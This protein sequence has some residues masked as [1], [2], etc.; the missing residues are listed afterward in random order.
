[1]ELSC[2]SEPQQPQ[3]LLTSLSFPINCILMMTKPFVVAVWIHW[4]WNTYILGNAE[5]LLLPKQ[6][7]PH[8]SMFCCHGDCQVSDSPNFIPIWFFSLS[9]PN[10]NSI[11]HHFKYFFCQY[12]QCPC[13][14][15]T[16]ILTGILYLSFPSSSLFQR[17][18]QLSDLHWSII[19][20]LS[21]VSSVSTSPQNFYVCPNLFYVTV[22]IEKWHLCNS[23]E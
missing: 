5:F 9:P 3:T 7:S 2:S 1:M 16:N 6:I 10:F 17:M 12:P 13:L 4:L 22:N 20:A 8:T 11:A 15:F 23:L 14:S 21:S 18:R 19:Y